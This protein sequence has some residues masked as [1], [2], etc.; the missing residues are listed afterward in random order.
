MSVWDKMKKSGLKTKLR[1]EIA[2]CERDIVG[3]KKTFGIELYD[4][5]TTDKQKLLGVSAG[6]LFKDKQ[7]EL[8]EPFERARDDMAGIQA[9]KD[10]KQKDLDVLEVNTADAM[11][12]ATL[13]E[14]MA[15]AGRAITN[16]SNST[17]LK[18]QMAL[19]DRDMKIRKEQFG[20]EVYD[21][22]KASEEGGLDGLS[23]QEKD[24]QACID[25]AKS[26]VASIEGKIKSKEDEI[27]MLDDEMNGLNMN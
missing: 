2:L 13:N 3:R 10:I 23:E 24:I 6:T 21:L 20:L 7:V 15:K 14:K 9:R 25:T 1:G 12:D 19:M 22:T 5:M 11:P 16:A 4:M 8:K 17:K 18:A 26:D 27:K